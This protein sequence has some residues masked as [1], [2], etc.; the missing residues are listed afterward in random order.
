MILFELIIEKR[1][2]KEEKRKIDDDCGQ[3][4]GGWRNIKILGKYQHVLNEKFFHYA[5]VVASIV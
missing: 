2:F 5:I 4:R 3:G 1:R